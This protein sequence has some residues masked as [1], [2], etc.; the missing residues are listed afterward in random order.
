MRKLNTKN[1]KG[2]SKVGLT[3]LGIILIAGT[4]LVTIDSVTKSAE[5]NQL[6]QE[7]QQMSLETKD[8]A[9]KIVEASSLNNVGIKANE[10]GYSKPQNIVYIGENEG[11]AARIP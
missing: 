5:I 3:I 10:L 2:S 9:E 11:V 4:V 8:L 1:E 6:A 7:E